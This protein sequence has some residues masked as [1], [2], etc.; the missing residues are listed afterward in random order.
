[1]KSP[2]PPTGALRFSAAA[3]VPWPV[4]RKSA[5]DGPRKITYNITI[6]IRSGGW[7]GIRTHGELAPTPVFKTGALNPSATHPHKTDQIL[8]KCRVANARGTCR[9]LATTTSDPIS[10]SEDE[11]ANRTRATRLSA[12]RTR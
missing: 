11:Y 9:Q 5:P 12:S 4:V 1:M 2:V 8:S 10:D 7:G 6:S 3:R